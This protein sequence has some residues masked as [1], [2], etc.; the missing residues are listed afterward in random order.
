MLFDEILASSNLSKESQRE[1]L[2]RKFGEKGFDYAT[3]GCSGIGIL[4]SARK[5]ILIHPSLKGEVSAA[6]VAQVERIFEPAYQ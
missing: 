2:V 5:V 1:C 4:A 6:R 3:R